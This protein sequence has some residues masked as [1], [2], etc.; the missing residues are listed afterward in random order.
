MFET[1]AGRRDL[2]GAGRA[3]LQD[4]AGFAGP[5]PDWAPPPDDAGE[6]RILSQ[7]EIDALLGFQP[8]SPEPVGPGLRAVAG[9]R[10]VP[11]ERLPSLEKVFEAVAARLTRTLREFFQDMVEVGVTGVRTVRVG[12]YLDSVPLPA[13]V[14]GFRVEP[15]GPGLVVLSC[16]LA[17]ATFDCLLGGKRGARRSRFSGRA[18]TRLEVELLRGLVEHLLSD[19]QHV[20]EPLAAVRL[21]L[22]GF[23]PEP[24]FATAA[25][26]TD[27]AVLATL[28][29]ALAGRQGEV[30]IVLP[31][32]TIAPMRDRLAQGASG[33]A[34][35]ADRTWE[36][37]LATELWRSELT[38]EAILHEA[39]VPLQKVLGLEVGSTLV[40]ETRP[41]DLVTL[42]CD[43]RVLARGRVGRMD[44][45][46]AIQVATPLMPSPAS[47]VLLETS[48]GGPAEIVES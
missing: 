42:A 19:L 17:F 8:P 36:R 32:E 26:A 33:G 5:A 30:D 47:L 35:G 43:G 37:H 7:A 6:D 13:Q 38:V 28:F 14:A 23:E 2:D 16:G 40:F 31:H 34:A 29:I 9:A 24:R 45:R 20:L 15:G 44:D 12:D 3:G 21:A 39:L 10:S 4:D 25:G 46:I 48:R 27:K 11:D 18:F 22:Q 1:A 41:A